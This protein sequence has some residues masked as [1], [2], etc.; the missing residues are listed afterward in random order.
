MRKLPRV[1]LAFALVLT[2]FPG[3]TLT[4]FAADPADTGASALPLADEETS[5]VG[6][7]DEGGGGEAYLEEGESPGTEEDGLEEAAPKQDEPSGAV[8]VPLAGS[9]IVPFADS[10][11]ETL[12]ELQNAIT[13]AGGSPTTI[14]IKGDIA[15]TSPI[16]IPAGSDI[17]LVSH[18]SGGSLTRNTTNSTPL[19]TVASG[20]K[21]TIGGNLKIDGAGRSGDLV[22]VLGECTLTG[23][24]VITGSTTR[25]V[26]VGDSTV[27]ALFTMEGGE[28]SDNHSTADNNYGTGIHVALAATFVMNGGKVTNNTATGSVSRGAGIFSNGTSYLNAGE[29]SYNNTATAYGGGMYI[30]HDSITYAKNILV[31]ENQAKTGGGIWCCNT[32]TNLLGYSITNSYA[33]F[34]NTATGTNAGNDIAHS[35]GEYPFYA[36]STCLGGGSIG[37]YD[38]FQHKSLEPDGYQYVITSKYLTA[39][40][41]EADKD[42]A[43][44]AATMVFKGNVSGTNSGGGIACNGALFAGELDKVLSV[45]K[46]FD[47]GTDSAPVTVHLYKGD[48][49]IESAVLDSSNSRFHTFTGLDADGYDQYRVVEE[50]I[51]GM[52]GSLKWEYDNGEYRYVTITNTQDAGSYGSLQIKKT[53]TGT[54]DNSLSFEFEIELGTETIDYP[55]TL[56]TSSSSSE[57]ALHVV[58]GKAKVT[59]KHGQTIVIKNIPVGTKYKVTEPSDPGFQTSLEGEGGSQEPGTSSWSG[60]IVED[61]TPIANWV[62]FTNA[63]TSCNFSAFKTVTGTADFEPATFEFEIRDDSGTAVAY[64]TVTPSA[65]DTPAPIKF[66]KESSRTTEIT[67]WTL[68]FTSGKTYKLVET[69]SEPGFNVTY[70][71]GQGS[72]HNEFTPNFSDSS[73]VIEV[74]ALNTKNAGFDFK[75]YKTVTGTADF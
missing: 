27:P 38:E 54:S 9:E 29:V 43:R 42:Q 37:W 16:S 58:D 5:A 20:G 32:G 3:N 41:S 74:T 8:V 60:E 72:D 6:E 62:T 67:D 12:S 71:G 49:Y 13:G 70:S 23:N 50:P 28:I 26:Y 15:V 52:E 40:I 39:E 33:I 61:A 53:V 47:K 63:K 51:A 66:Y 44:N 18:S 14:T 69:S 48:T 46:A 24:A 2:L 68:V 4:A 1:A 59:L 22:R 56:R 19:I 17:T 75:A 36:S 31:T 30:E 25:G 45:R 64:G 57:G 55:Y 10:T 34:D 35:G 65:A 21:L 7:A 73:Q 11:V